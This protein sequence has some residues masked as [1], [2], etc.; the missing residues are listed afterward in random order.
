LRYTHFS[1]SPILANQRQ[2]GSLTLLHL[3]VSFH[4]SL[5]SLQ[6]QAL[7]Q[8]QSYPENYWYSAQ[9]IVG[10]VLFLF[11]ARINWQVDAHLT[12]LRQQSAGYQ[13]PVGGWFDGFGV[14]APHY[15]GEMV[16]WMGFAVAANFST[17][18]VSFVI[19]TASNLIPRG[20]AHHA[21]YQQYF[22]DN[23]PMQRKAVIPYI[24]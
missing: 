6:A 22:G 16:Q 17:A 14:S 21:W 2:Q 20:V 8:F 1:L 3:L 13:I 19:F 5:H 12:R 23:Y 15:W 11:G 18:A 4:I 10:V 24:W 9:F 7:C